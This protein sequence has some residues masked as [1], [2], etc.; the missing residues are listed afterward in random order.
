MASKIYLR[1]NLPKEV[2]Y[3]YNETCKTLKKEIEENTKKIK[4]P[5]MYIDWQI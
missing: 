1:I 3:L 2:K 4:R 5:S